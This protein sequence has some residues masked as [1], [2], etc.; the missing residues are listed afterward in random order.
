MRKLIVL[1][2]IFTYIEFILA[3]IIWFYDLSNEDSCFYKLNSLYIEAYKFPRSPGAWYICPRLI[4]LKEFGNTWGKNSKKKKRK[5]CCFCRRFII[6]PTN[7]NF[8]FFKEWGFSVKLWRDI[9]LEST[10]GWSNFDPKFP[11]KEELMRQ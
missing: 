11:L 9:L 7:K 2:M 10:N 6:Q 5:Y 1:V 3:L 8:G 4:V